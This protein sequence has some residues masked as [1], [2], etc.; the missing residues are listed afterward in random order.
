MV[1]S[2]IIVM[3][4]DEINFMLG[5]EHKLKQNMEKNVPTFVQLKNYIVDNLQATLDEYNTTKASL[6]GSKV[7]AN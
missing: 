5:I 1:K 3:I 7:V 4:E 6:L 2:D